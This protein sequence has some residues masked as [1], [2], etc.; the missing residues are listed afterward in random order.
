M[1]DLF[2]NDADGFERMLEASLDGHGMSLPEMSEA[3]ANAHGA[4]ATKALKLNAA[5]TLG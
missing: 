1:A 5:L 2:L 4:P 3:F